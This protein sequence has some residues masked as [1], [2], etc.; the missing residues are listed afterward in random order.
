MSGELWLLKEE[1]AE[2]AGCSRRE[3]ERMDREGEIKSRP[4]E[5]CKL[6][7]GPR[8]RE[9]AASSLSSE[10][11][12]ASKL[13]AILMRRAASEAKPEDSAQ[14]ALAIP[15][16]IE[17]V[18][19]SSDRRSTARST[20]AI[21]VSPEKRTKMQ[22]RYQILQPLLDW[23]KGLRPTFLNSDGRIFTS[24]DQLAEY[25]GRQQTPPRSLRTLY[26]WLKRCKQQGEVGLVPKARADRGKSRLL[27]VWYPDAAKY[28]LAKYAEGPY[29]TLMIY[30]SL[31]RD[32]E[33][34]YP[35]EPFLRREGR[36]DKFAV[37]ITTLRAYLNKL[38][39]PIRDGARLTREQHDGKY[40]PYL[41]T[42]IAKV[43]VNQ[44]WVCDHRVY[45]LIGVNDCFDGA[46]EFA[47]LRI[48]ETC[49]V[50]MRTR[51]VVGSV[52]DVTPSSATIARALYQAISR[53]GIPEILYADNGKDFKKIG[54]A[55]TKQPL[56]LDED[57]R[58]RIN[59]A[60]DALL[61]RLGIRPKYCVPKHP[62]SKQVE[63]YFST[64]S[65]RFDVIFG[66][67]YAGR[68]PSLRP[69]ACREAEHQHHEFLA[70]H[71]ETTPLVPLSYL[72][73]MHRQW[74]EEFN[75]SHEHSG[76]GMEG[77][78]PYAVMDELLPASERR[79]PDMATLAPLFWSQS[80]LT[81]SNS[82]VRWT[83]HGSS[84][85][86]EG[87]TTEDAAQMYLA[88][89]RKVIVRRDSENVAQAIA[90]TD[91]GEFLARL[92]CKELVDRVVDVKTSPVTERAIKHVSRLRAKLYR[93]TKQFWSVIGQGVPTELEL[94][95]ERSRK[96]LQLNPSSIPAVPPTQTD[97]D[98]RKSGPPLVSRMP[99]AVG[100][101]PSGPRY[102]EDVADRLR[103]AMRETAAN[104]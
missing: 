57:G 71:R 39:N 92:K 28:V 74:T 35:G 40:A 86:Y 96:S 87:E 70:G 78:T 52:W 19:Q 41:T 85:E 66:S 75:A 98:D 58:I 30:Q 23:D 9:Y 27:D 14:L 15:A 2:Y 3:V 83:E 10:K 42:A 32:W 13:Q 60:S 63:S 104:D 100:G 99:A 82:Q 21:I 88:N 53:F 68:K 6:K 22:R 97:A 80:Q 49:I 61:L 48:W 26:R 20:E 31:M 89:G 69:D 29:S 24:R 73:R 18:A 5:N 8:P 59:A 43:R 56:D 72:I 7:P 11:Q 4:S 67:S 38:P 90:C 65:K 33:T 95:E 45:D 91:A 93:A 44:I 36:E 77:R 94:L 55:Y 81:V 1:M 84:L 34:L 46:D 50:D 79:I 54:G 101:T 64:V 103:A 25:I 16:T 47:A 12:D 62:Q 76:H 17:V 102:T 37:S 51:V